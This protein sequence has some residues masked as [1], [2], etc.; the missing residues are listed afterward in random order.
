MLLEKHL[1]VTAQTHESI[2]K[3]MQQD[4]QTIVNKILELDITA[5][6]AA[7][8]KKNGEVLKECLKLTQALHG[9]ELVTMSDVKKVEDLLK[10]LSDSLSA[11]V[12]EMNDM[13]AEV[14][15]RDGSL[16]LRLVAQLAALKTDLTANQAL[17]ERNTSAG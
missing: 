14:Q 3:L 17:Q 7:K 1:A 2:K 11:R 5:E 13:R 4:T 12:E 8:D 10:I 6:T 16:E 9:A 15:Q